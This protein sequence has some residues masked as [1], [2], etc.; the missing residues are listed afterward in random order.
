M[1]TIT[2][3]RFDVLNLGTDTA[4]VQIS[5]L[6]FSQEDAA[7]GKHAHFMLKEIY[8]QPQTV[9]NALRGRAGFRRRDGEVRRLEH[10]GGG[11]ARH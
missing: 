1:A 2:P 6:E 3:E 11:T 9:L 7:R 8:E 10:D 5:N 4:N